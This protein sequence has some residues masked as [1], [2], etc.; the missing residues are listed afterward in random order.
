MCEQFQRKL[1]DRKKRI[2]ILKLEIIRLKEEKEAIL[3]RLKQQWCVTAIILV[4]C[5]NYIQF[6]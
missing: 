6:N 5:D 3:E 2:K 4:L 1:E